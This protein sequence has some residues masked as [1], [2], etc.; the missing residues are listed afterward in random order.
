MTLNPDDVETQVFREKMRGYDQDEVDAFLDK[1]ADRLRQLAAERDE[2]VE[3]IG[4]IQDDATESMDTERLLKRTLI[5]AQRTA[6]QA[7]ADAN[8][9]AETTTADADR[10]AAEVV[11]QAERKVAELTEDAERRAAE[12]TGEAERRASELLDDA[13]REAE[14][15]RDTATAELESVHRAVAELQRFRAEYRERVHAVIAEQLDAFDRAGELPDLPP[16]LVDVAREADET[17]ARSE[18][19][20]RRLDPV[21]AGRPPGDEGP[22]GPGDPAGGGPPGVGERPNADG[23]PSAGHAGAEPPSAD[24]PA[25][26]RPGPDGAGVASEQPQRREVPRQPFGGDRHR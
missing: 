4:R 22:R 5:M 25:A 18:L 10:Y 12:T 23:D 26:V 8:E 24:R 1:V 9:Q 14:Y 19:G 3:R 6:D 20:P 2:L 17:L 11:S 13:R 16:G 21:R 7:V 15:A